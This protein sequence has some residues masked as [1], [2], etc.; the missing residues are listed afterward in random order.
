M[1]KRD[2]WRTSS[3]SEQ[4]GTC[5]ALNGTLDAVRDTKNGDVLR[6][7]GPAAAALVAAAVTGRRLPEYR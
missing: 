2:H 7:P 3:H 6:L 4:N 5:V 1:R